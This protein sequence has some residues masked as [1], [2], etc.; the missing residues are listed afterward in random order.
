M[1]RKAEEGKDRVMNQMCWRERGII[2]LPDA[3]GVGKMRWCFEMKAGP[4]WI[5]SWE[6][7]LVL[8]SSHVE[9]ECME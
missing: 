6:G 3:D 2:F 9:M 8:L 5:F 4:D 1:L 7:L